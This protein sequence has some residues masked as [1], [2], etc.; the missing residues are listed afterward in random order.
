MSRAWT[1]L[2]CLVAG[3]GPAF[4]QAPSLEPVLRAELAFA[5][6]ADEKGIRTAFLTWL[7]E[8]AS[9]FSPRMTNRKEQY[10]PEP[11][12]PG[13]LVWYPEAMGLAASGDLAWSL[14]PWTYAV[15]KGGAVLVH[16]HFLSVW[17]KQA[18]GGWKAVAD[19][20]VPHAA[21]ERPVEPF[22]IWDAAPMKRLTQSKGSDATPVLLRKEADLAAAWVEKGGL[23]LLPELAKAGRVLRPRRMPLRDPA[24][25]EKALEA[26]R[27]GARWEPARIQV[28]AGGD[29]AWTCGES[30]PDDRGATASFLRI[31]TLEGGDW[32]VL[33]DVRLP[34][35]APPK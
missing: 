23:A 8:D 2:P 11:G 25:I 20:G 18:G 16:G 35:P 7:T 1:V 17:R 5:R 10:G 30:G 14:G 6:M 3:V 19:I 13:H 32:K 22:A 9:V 21:P 4:A 27:P 28:A 34:H 29:L 33:F 15:K 31:W 24:E 12:D 26:D